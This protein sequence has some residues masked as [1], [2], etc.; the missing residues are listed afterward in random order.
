MIVKKPKFE[1]LHRYVELSSGNEQNICE[2]TA[3]K[4]GE[5]IYEDY[6]HGYQ[7]GDTLNTMSVT[8][9]VMA[10]LTGIAIDKGHIKSVDQRVLEFFPDYKVKRGEKT[11][12]N[13]T[14]R[15]LL[16]MTAPYK[17]RSEPWTRVCTS[18]DWTKAALDILGGRNGITGEFKYATLG[19]QILSGVI[20]NASGMKMIDF[21][22]TYLFEPLGIPSHKNADCSTKEEQ[23]DFLM[24]K[25]PK[26]NV[27]FADPKRANTAGW[28][29]ALSANDL[30]SIGLMCLQK[31]I[32]NGKRIVS[33]EWIDAVSTPYISLDEKFGNMSYGFLWWII[34]ANKR[35]Y[36]AIGDGGNIIYVNTEK[37]ICVGI[38]G[39]F[40]PRIF[41]R[42]QFIQKYIE[43]LL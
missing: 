6:W 9:S 12:Y 5:V 19:I 42:V 2:I 16:T 21:A 24:S 15:H 1:Q 37:G 33:A 41:D 40:K 25:E 22:N 4:N 39:T 3:I 30:A 7:H 31:G 32:Y 10:L 27:W 17:Y 13:V 38:A 29:L 26:G 23:F 28:G 43:P 11:I 8:K 14:L 35:N 36:A 34:N 20:I 18:D